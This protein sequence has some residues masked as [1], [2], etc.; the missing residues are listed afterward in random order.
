MK[1]DANVSGVP[2]HFVFNMDE[3]G[4]RDGADRNERTGYARYDTQGD[5]VGVPVSR[6][7]KHIS[8]LA[9]IALDGSYIRPMGMRMI[10]QSTPRIFIFL[11]APASI[12]ILNFLKRL[13]GDFSTY[14]A[15]DNFCT[16]RHLCNGSVLI[17]SVSTKPCKFA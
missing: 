2:A 5:T 8:L 12:S 17:C 10:K 4:H 7:G 11:F 1:W 3:M 6:Q 16:H 14:L 9:Y 13:D 15:V